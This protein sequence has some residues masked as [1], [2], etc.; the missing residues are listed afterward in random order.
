MS[1]S[2]LYIILFISLCIII[3][4]SILLF[5]A[6]KKIHIQ[7]T[8]FKVENQ[9]VIDLLKKQELKFIDARLKGQEKERQRIARDLHDRLGSML[10]MV[11]IHY[12]SVEDNI[13]SL[14]TQSQEQY[15]KA[16]ELLDA[17]CVEVRKIA[18]NMS[19]GVLSKFGLIPALEDLVT[20]IKE[21]NQIDVSLIT[22]GIEGRLKN[23]LEIIIYRI[24]QELV[25]NILKHSKSTEFIIQ[26][27]LSAETL[28]IVVE[29]NGKGFDVKNLD[30]LSG[31]GLKN[32]ASRVNSVNG[33]LNIDSSFENGTTISIDIPNKNLDYD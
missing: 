2:T 3:T 28:N 18:H 20:A 33:Q 23:D 22:H 21:S 10:S 16:N 30:E 17:A 31:M 4:Q 27:V 29:D 25:N 6:R 19:S 26:L 24:I 14:K 11:K 8:K 1:V 9:K 15:A 7:N 13:N 12:K 32:V 5:K